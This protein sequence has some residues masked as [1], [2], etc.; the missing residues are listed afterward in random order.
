MT[1][2]KQPAEFTWGD[3]V[4]SVVRLFGEGKITPENMERGIWG[5]I[6]E[7]KKLEREVA[8]QTAENMGSYE[9]A[10]AIRTAE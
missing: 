4:R 3:A 1:I 10:E 2:N 6:E 9:I 5:M 7:A 8:A